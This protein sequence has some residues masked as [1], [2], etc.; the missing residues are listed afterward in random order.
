MA[1]AAR[2]NDENIVEEVL[3]IPAEHQH[4]V[5][6]Y[7]DEL[8]LEGRWLQTSFNTHGG[9]NRTGGEALRKNFAGIG[10]SYDEVRDAFIPP[11]PFPSWTLSEN[12]CL[13]KPPVAYPTDG[14]MYEWSEDD[15]DWV[16]V[17]N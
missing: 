6:D 4:R 1:H 8:G 15:L 5:Q 7:M 9:I 3:V 11:K 16:A 12:T 2:I 14:I 13:W 17:I 10:Y